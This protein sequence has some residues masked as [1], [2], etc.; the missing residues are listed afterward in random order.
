MKKFIISKINANQRIDKF[1]KRNYKNAPLSFI[2]KTFRKKDIKVNGHR[3]KENYIII[4]NDIVEV[5]INDK[6][7]EEFQTNEEFKIV[8]YP[9]DIVYEDKN[10]LM[11]NKDK[12]VL[13]HGDSH[14][15]KYTLSNF[16]ISYLIN[17]HVICC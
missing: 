13:I 14:E 9:L 16:V 3:V 1:I 17:K 11:I 5:Y 10:I 8:D 12:G 4:E 2:Y 6:K 7:L 15:Q